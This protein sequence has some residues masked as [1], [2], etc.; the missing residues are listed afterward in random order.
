MAENGISR[1]QQ[2]LASH[3]VHCQVEDPKHVQ[4]ISLHDWLPN[5]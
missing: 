5:L 1:V 4:K 2:K 3:S